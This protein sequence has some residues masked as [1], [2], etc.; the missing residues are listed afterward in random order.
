M[1]YN[2]PL[3]NT[4]MKLPPRDYNICPNRECFVEFGNDA[5]EFQDDPATWEA[6]KAAWLANGENE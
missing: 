3:C 4:E 2:C 6:E 1:T 5:P